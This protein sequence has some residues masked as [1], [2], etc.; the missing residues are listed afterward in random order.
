M[1]D[2]QAYLAN[3]AS[4]KAIGT[5]T[6]AGVAAGALANNVNAFPNLD[7]L[8]GLLADVN[9]ASA[10]VAKSEVYLNG[11][12]LSRAADGDY[13]GSAT[14]V[15]DYGYDTDAAAG[16]P[17]PGLIFLFDLVAGDHIA[18]MARS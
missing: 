8:G 2:I 12:L 11:M 7:A 3:N 4:A 15:E 9:G 14:L 17:A 1:A 6:G 10:S 18:V 13:S 5:I 16:S